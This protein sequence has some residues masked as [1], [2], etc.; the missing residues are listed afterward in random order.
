MS[1]HDDDVPHLTMLLSAERLRA[2]TDLTGDYK[3]AIELH[4][5]TLRLGANLM[6]IIATVEIALRNTVFENLSRHFGTP[7]WLLGSA[8]PFQWRVPERDNI[9]KAQDSARRAEYAKLSQAE[10]HALDDIAF[11]TGCPAGLTHSARAK[12][13]RRHIAVSDGKVIAELTFYIWK[14]I[15]GPDYEHSLWRPTLKRTFP[16][17]KVRRAEVAGHLEV[18][19]QARNRLAH[20]EPLLHQR[21]REMMAS[22]R[23]ISERLGMGTATP[24]SPLARLIADDVAKTKARAEALHSDLQ[25]FRA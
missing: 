23:F 21:F 7:G 24:D 11:P 16:D 22:V 8:Q 15:Y 10:K 12:Q 1:I 2:L 3:A 14:R 17:K 9:F 25:S 19:Y 13:R 6:T 18:L 20:H 5:E 4:Q